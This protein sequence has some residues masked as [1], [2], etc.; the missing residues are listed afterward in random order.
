MAF[1]TVLIPVLLVTIGTGVRPAPLTAQTEDSL[2]PILKAANQGRLSRIRELLAAGAEV[3]ARGEFEQ[4]ALMVMAEAGN[5][6]GVTLLLEAGADPD[7][8][9]R[10]GL[11]P[12]MLAASKGFGS[13][14]TILLDAGADPNL[15]D[16]DGDL[17]LGYYAAAQG[18]M[19]VVRLLLDGG[20]DINGAAADGFTPLHYAAANGHTDIVNYLITRGA[21]VDPTTREQ[22]TPWMYA[23]GGN[24]AEIRSLLESQGA[25][26][27]PERAEAIRLVAAGERLAREG[28]VV[29]AFEQLDSAA[30]V[31][32]DLTI[33]A[34]SWASLCWFGGVWDH[35]GDAIEACDRSVE[36]TPESS[37]YYAGRRDNRGLVRALLQ[38]FDG[39]IEDFR[40]FADRS[41]SEAARATREEWI[42]ALENGD[43]PFTP[44]RLR[45]MR[46]P[47]SGPQAT[48][49]VVDGVDLGSIL[50]A[51]TDLPEGEA[52]DVSS[53]AGENGRSL[54][55]RF[56]AKHLVFHLGASTVMGLSTAV[57]VHTDVESARESFDGLVAL[58]PDEVAQIFGPN[59]A[60]AMGFE[61][62]TVI[63]AP[64]DVPDLGD[65]N[66]AWTLQVV[67]AIATFDVAMIFGSRGTYTFFAALTGPQ[68]RVHP[69]D[70]IALMG[71][72][73]RRIIDAVPPQ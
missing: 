62:D 64:L 21:E 14:A 5:E 46:N 54:Q 55:R 26:H 73:D 69:E 19:D 16:E 17:P 47:S 53:E 20:A 63:A 18:R 36:A 71:D 11:T 7:A 31:D 9:N 8:H 13:I 39:A 66:V 61:S 23:V 2:P 43:N 50:P 10:I 67:T 41:S 70:L 22:W 42:G 45:A 37:R 60:Q 68:G 72:V 29:E 57:Q 34:G 6:T 49:A 30:A 40:F 44:E 3:D 56:N 1:R 4:T 52:V 33:L 28:S 12:L 65:R 59:L 24:H 48:E 32:P 51:I 25:N 15:G 35:A 38:D 58:T 27:S